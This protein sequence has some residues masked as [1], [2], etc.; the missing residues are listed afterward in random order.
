MAASG[1]EEVISP[2]KALYA[3][4]GHWESLSRAEQHLY[5]ARALA[6]KHPSWV[7]CG[8]TA[9]A[10]H[11]IAVAHGDLGRIHVSVEGSRRYTPA[12]IVAMHAATDDRVVWKSGIP[13]TSLRRS[14]F[15]CLC[16]TDFRQGLAIADSVLRISGM[17]RSWLLDA[18]EQYGGQGTRGIRCAR[19]AASHADARSE[20][21][22]E[23]IA[24]AAMIENGYLMPELQVGIADPFEA[25]R[26]YRVDFLW[27]LEGGYGVIG[28][29]DGREKY[30]N[31]EMTGGRSAI[32]VLADERIRESRLSA[33]GMPVMRICYADVCN[34]MRFMQLMAAY[35]IPYAA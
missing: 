31:P 28:E 15:D 1:A 2:A 26:E 25:H 8:F 3:D 35:G 5:I 11:G 17:D 19:K 30:V 33:T 14:A 10:A 13:V 6:K 24:R 22:G 16:Q 7:F 34:D 29:F 21:G 27:R 23:S 4:R 32:D 20:S 12:G 9:A 18:L